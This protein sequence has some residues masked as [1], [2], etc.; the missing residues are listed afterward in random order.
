[1]LLPIVTVFLVRVVELA[2]AAEAGRKAGLPQF[3]NADAGRDWAGA[4]YAT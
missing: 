3:A 1:L 2:K 4:A